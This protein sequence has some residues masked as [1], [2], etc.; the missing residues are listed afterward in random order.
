MAKKHLTDAE[1]RDLK[2]PANGNVITYDDKVAGFG[3]RVTA[4][5]SKSFI[6]NYRTRAGRE[7]RVT[8]GS[9]SS[10][11]TTAARAEAKRLRRLVEAGGDPLGDI[12]AERE[13]PSM[14]DLIE[15]FTAEHLSRKRSGT[16]TDYRRMLDS[17]IGPA[18][19]HLK[20]ADVV[21]A[22]ID[23]LH[24]KITKAG[25]LY[26]A[27]RVVAV[28]SK[29]F[30]LSIKWQ[31][32]DNNPCVGIERNT[33][34]HR[35]RYLKDDELAR[36]VEALA[37]HPDRQAANIIR[38]LMLTGCRKGEALSAR[39][40]DLDL[41]KGLWSKPAASVKQNEPH[42]APLSAPARQLLSEIAAAAKP[43]ILGTYVFPGKGTTG[44]RVDIKRDWRQ[45]C[46]DAGIAG[47]R[48]HDLRHSFASQLASSG[49][50]LPLI[51]AL[52]GHSR[53]ATTARYTHLFDDARMAA[54]ERVG[55]LIDA[56][57]N[58]KAGDTVEQFPGGRSRR[59]GA[60]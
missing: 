60:K 53:P 56:A 19:K 55:A 44:H 47:L 48:V 2:I 21:Y 33:E 42:E 57:G 1:V 14:A 39:W 16:A 23:R 54:V 41:K 49:S 59:P 7:R 9:A 22:D 12:E 27:N 8:V 3:C 43:R 15:R 4:A 35:R 28:L 36:L 13:A 34:H 18:L 46:R 50:S 32:R 10:W 37:K 30:S 52:L 17:H 11:Q 20:V 24:Q 5:G 38:L 45:L 29:M 26:R 40:A 6:F 51:G 58:G 31:M 25:H